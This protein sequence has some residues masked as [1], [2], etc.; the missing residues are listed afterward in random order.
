M[1]LSVEIKTTDGKYIDCWKPA[2]RLE[3]FKGVFTKEKA[4]KGCTCGGFMCTCYEYD[5]YL[6]KETDNTGDE[7]LREYL[8][9]YKELLISY[10]C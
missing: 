8:K 9:K 3:K 6:V 1:G 10:S 5:D 4:V 7:I 2:E